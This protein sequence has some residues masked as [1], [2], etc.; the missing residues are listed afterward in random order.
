MFN[1]IIMPAPYKTFEI[2]V[3]SIIGSVIYHSFLYLYI[4]TFYAK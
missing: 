2:S 1:I 3:I 4:C